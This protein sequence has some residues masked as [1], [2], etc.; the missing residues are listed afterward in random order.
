VKTPRPINPR[1]NF[2]ACSGADGKKSWKIMLRAAIRK[3]MS[4]FHTVC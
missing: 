1:L 2:E 4:S 3:L